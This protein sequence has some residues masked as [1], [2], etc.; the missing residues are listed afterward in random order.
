VRLQAALALATLGDKRA[1]EPFIDCLKTRGENYDVQMVAILGLGELGDH[2][3]LGVLLGALEAD[4]AQAR[5]AAAEALGKIGLPPAMTGLIQAL[6]DEE[7]L[8]R[9]KA[10][11]A[12]GA[13]GDGRA[14]VSVE[15][16]LHDA[17]PAVRAAAREALEQIR[18]PPEP[19]VVPG[20]KPQHTGTL[21]KGDRTYRQYVAGDAKS[22][23]AFLAKRKPEY[24]LEYITVETPEG[25]WGKDAEGLYL[26]RLLLWQ[27][28]LRL[29]QCAGTIVTDRKRER[30]FQFQQVGQEDIDN[31]VVRVRCGKCEAS[32]FD[33][34][35]YQGE[36]VVRCPECRTHN[37]VRMKITALCRECGYEWR[38]GLDD[39]GVSCPRC[40]RRRGAEA[41]L[42][43]EKELRIEY[44]GDG[45][46]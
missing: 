21:R 30:D 9:R 20:E 10:T 28:D 2:R 26:A 43:G 38:Y 25:I 31:V 44:G 17:A 33:G 4:D 36:T 37:L 5:A 12:L 40:R 6:A 13:I 29:A 11:A 1:V 39:P 15:W 18:E 3:A 22:A 19:A 41:A 32:W 45:R 34:V 23:R 7:P 16:T 27:R 46:P 24:E 8:V 14:R 35:G 42:E